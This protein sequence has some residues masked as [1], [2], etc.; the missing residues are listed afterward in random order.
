[1]VLADVTGNPRWD[2]A[3]SI[4]I[5]LLLGAIAITLIVEMKSLLIGESA[6]PEELDRIA[7]AMSGHA[8][9]RRV[10]HMRTQHLGPEELLVGAK[11]E[12]DP[13]LEGPALADAINEVETAVRAAV[14]A[15][16]VMYLEPDLFRTAAPPPPTST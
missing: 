2:A 11:L 1:V 8:R 4:A 10:I 7:G 13:D 12:L 9:V 15:A 14:P 6:S 16:R 5:G 3:G